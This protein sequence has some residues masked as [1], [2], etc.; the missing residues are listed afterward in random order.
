MKQKKVFILKYVKMN[1]N[2]FFKK[3]EK[4]SM[5]CLEEFQRTWQ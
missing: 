4:R 1:H 5:G 3:R 2:L